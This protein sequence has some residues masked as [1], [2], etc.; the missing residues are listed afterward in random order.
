MLSLKILDI[1]TGS[2]RS[3]GQGPKLSTTAGS[4]EM[5]SDML[6]EGGSQPHQF[7]FVFEAKGK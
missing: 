1:E 4:L 6:Y 2:D 5:C 3:L 7:I